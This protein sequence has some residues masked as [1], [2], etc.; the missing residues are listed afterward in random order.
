M[1]QKAMKSLKFRSLCFPD[2]IEARGVHMKQDLPTYFYR[3]DGYKVWD[4]TRRSATTSFYR[5]MC[6]QRKK[7]DTENKVCDCSTLVHS[8]VSDVV[9]IYYKDQNTVEQDQEIQ[10]FVKDVHNFGMQGFESCGECGAK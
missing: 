10:A 8:F 6:I 7:S 1:I 9:H 5:D 2:S 4:A 3:D